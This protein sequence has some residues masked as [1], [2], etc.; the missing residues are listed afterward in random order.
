MPQIQLPDFM[1]ITCGLITYLLGEGINNRIPLLRALS[2]PDPVTGGLLVA[3]LFYALHAAGI[4]EVSFDTHARDILLL[5]FFTGIG[6]NA[7]VTD[8]VKGGRP[9][10][11]LV[12]LTAVL[13]LAQMLV[14]GL[15]AWAAGLPMGMGA[16]L[17]S[18]SLLGG[19]GTV[20]AWSPELTA[21]GLTGAPEIGIAVA[22]LGLVVGSV[23]GG[24]LGRFL[25]GRGNLAS[26]EPAEVNPVGL[27]DTAPAHEPITRN[28][29]MRT[30]LW[31]YVCIILG[32]VAQ[33]LI[34]RAGLNLPLFVPCL[35]AGMIVGNLMS[36]VP[37]VRP[38][39]HTAALS[40]VSEFALGVFL[41]VSLM[42]LQLWA[43]AGM[44]GTLLAVLAVQTAMALAFSYFLVFRFLGR[45]YPAA[46]LT[47]GYSSFVLGATPT[48]I[49]TMTAVTKR[50]G[51][52]QSAFIVLPLV[53]ALF[54]DLANALVTQ[55]Y[56]NLWTP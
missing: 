15:A 7:R 25:I 9:L 49:A 16:V 8:L 44:A 41:A 5:L 19:H 23:V 24:P 10:V 45:D 48:A 40:L 51:P 17:G 55:G 26:D 47:A 3:A 2:I 12:G 53:S 52:C 18:T 42:T 11:I 39:S 22:T 34:L 4:A 43:L 20:I 37:F 46:V 54:V 56:L 30:L 38:V 29:L 13:L 6:L 36:L 32:F 1:A 28:A 14:G 31:L 27:S 21:R 33:Q 35:L 50:Y